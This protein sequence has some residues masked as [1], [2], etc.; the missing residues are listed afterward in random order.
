MLRLELKLILLTLFIPQ[1][2]SFFIAGLRLNLTRVIFIVLTPLL[3]SRVI[4]K[5]GTGR[6]RFVA[7]DLFVILASI[8]MFVGPTVTTSFGDALVHSGPIVLEWLIAY[9]A[10]RVLLSGDGDSLQFMNLLCLVIAFVA[11]DGLLD[12]ATGRYFT[13]ELFADLGGY[14]EFYNDDRYRFGLQ[15]ATGPLEHPILFGFTCAIGLLF[16]SA[17]EIRRR[18]FC[19]AACALGVIISFSSAPQQCALMGSGLLIYSRMFSGLPRKWFLLSL[20]PIVAA[21]SLFLA[22][23]TPFGHI[24]G[25]VTLDPSTAYFRLFIWNAVGPVILAN[26]YFGILPS[27]YEY[28]G[29]VDSVWL[30]LSL[31]YGMV[32]SIFVGASLIGCCSLPTDNARARLSHTEERLGT[33]LGI[34]M[35]V[36]IFMGFTVDFWGDT[37]ILIGLLVGVRAHLGELGQLNRAAEFGPTSTVPL[38][39][40]G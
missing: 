24:F 39:E 13:R 32:C 27:D 3:F 9:L 12:T 14:V 4:R 2:L 38:L 20:P 29:S 33:I 37:W 30:H 25:F 11:L 16:A 28:Q 40:S 6:Y 26:P 18:M 31:I 21:V 35:F 36:T 7:S 23:D 34:V 8:W 1:E 5:M 22:T 19:I 10:T 15:R 17:I